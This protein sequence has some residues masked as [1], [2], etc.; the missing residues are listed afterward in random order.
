MENVIRPLWPNAKFGTIQILSS[1]YCLS[2]SNFK[3]GCWRT[4]FLYDSLK[5]PLSFPTLS[6]WNSM[7]ILEGNHHAWLF[8]T[9]IK[10]TLLSLESISHT[11]CFPKKL[12]SMG[13]KTIPRSHCLY[14]TPTFKSALQPIPLGKRILE[15][16]F[17]VWILSTTMST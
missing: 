9:L 16:H 10:I 8:T 6:L 15:S 17:I 3:H 13:L 12:K 7:N 4:C 11:A 5:L 1:Q 2:S 14:Y